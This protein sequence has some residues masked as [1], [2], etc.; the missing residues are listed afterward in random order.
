MTKQQKDRL[1]NAIA[2]Y[3]QVTGLSRF[4]IRSSAELTARAVAFVVELREAAAK[5]YNAK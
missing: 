3:S 5:A 1:T 4:A 2:A